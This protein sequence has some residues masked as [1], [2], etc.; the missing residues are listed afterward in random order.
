LRVM[1]HTLG[2]TTFLRHKGISRL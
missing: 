1:A 2:E